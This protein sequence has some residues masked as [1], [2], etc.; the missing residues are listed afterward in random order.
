MTARNIDIP[1]QYD[2]KML[3]SLIRALRDL[4][5]SAPGPDV[6]DKTGEVLGLSD[7][8]LDY[9]KNEADPQTAFAWRLYWTR[10]ALEK[11]GLVQNPSRGMWQLTQKGWQVREVTGP[12][13]DGIKQAIRDY[14]SELRKSKKGKKQAGPNGDVDDSNQGATYPPWKIELIDR[15]RNVD[16]YGFEHLCKNFL[17][18]IGIERV[19][20]T[21]KSN[22]QGIDGF[23]VIKVNDVIGFKM[24][25]QCK[26]YVGQV[27]APEIDKFRGSIV[28]KFEKGLLITTG[29]FTG[30][31]RDKANDNNPIIDLIDGEMLADKMADLG[32]GVKKDQIVVDENYFAKFN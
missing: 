2:P 6:I 23:G 1:H 13:I 4:G 27:G 26:R 25:F 3:N 5:G 10:W 7:E 28:N 8:Q 32:L 17:I 31:A 29:T 12:H 20:V 9:K 15:L 24:A 22:D 19:Q 14:N 30:G 21:S 18:S 16:P 11:Y